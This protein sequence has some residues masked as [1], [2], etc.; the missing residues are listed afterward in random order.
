MSRIPAHTVEDVPEQSQ[1]LLERLKKNTG[2]LMNIHAGMAHSPIVLATYAA[3]N[4]AAAERS[5]F[6]DVRAGPTTTPPRGL[7]LSAGRL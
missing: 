1:L 5:P 4:E 2:R 7:S 6:D 3:I